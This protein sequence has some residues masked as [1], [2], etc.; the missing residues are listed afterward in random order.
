MPNDLN[1]YNDKTVLQMLREVGHLLL[2]LMARL[3]LALLK[4]LLRLGKILLRL[5]CKLILLVIDLTQRGIERAN[6]FWHDNDTQEKLRKL[7]ALLRR[8]ASL[9]LR[10]TIVAAQA[11]WR[12]LCWTG[13][14]LRAGSIVLFHS[15][16]YAVLHIGPTL[17][18]AGRALGR[19]AE[20][21]GRRLR[22]MGRGLKKWRRQRQRAWRSFRR[23]KGFKGLLMDLGI[24]LKQQI[25]NYVEEQPD[26]APVDESADEL[27]AAS[28]RLLER[29]DDEE[30]QPDG[31]HTEGTRIHT[32]GRG[33]YNAMKRIVEDD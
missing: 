23:N 13:R 15:T 4:L 10:A 7:K 18:A 5:T 32:F 24:W 2:V 1:P 16:V 19:L 33:I 6:A 22:L 25:S 17:K 30:Q 21:I 12:G 11:S 8:A 3:L 31:N 9:T 29:N 20:A 14:K 28:Q 26:D 27:D